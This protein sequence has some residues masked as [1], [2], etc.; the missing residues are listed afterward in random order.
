MGT[1]VIVWEYE[2]MSRDIWYLVVT[3]NVNVLNATKLYT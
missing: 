2:K 3:K 1:G